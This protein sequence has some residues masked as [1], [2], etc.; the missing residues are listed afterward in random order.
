VRHVIGARAIAQPHPKDRLNVHP[1]GLRRD[2]Q[3]VDAPNGPVG[4]HGT[5]NRRPIIKLAMQSHRHRLA[6]QGR[7]QGIG[8][9]SQASQ[10]N[11]VLRQQLRKLQPDQALVL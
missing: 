9:W 11:R 5:P 4:I 6:G 2:A 3:P 1:R 7:W 8:H 10:L